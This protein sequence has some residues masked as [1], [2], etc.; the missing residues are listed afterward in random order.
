[1][2]TL[3]RLG[4]LGLLLLCTACAPKTGPQ[5]SAPADPINDI[6]RQYVMLSLEIGMHEE[7]YIDAYYGPAEWKRAAEAAP[8]ALPDLAAAVDALDASL[9]AVDVAGSERLVQ[10]RVTFLRA[11]LNAARTRLR[12]LR[13][14]KLSFRQES[15]GLFGATPD[16]QPLASYDPV[17]AN[18]EALLPGPGTLAE[19]MDAFQERF[20]IPA[21]RLKPVF[22]RAIAE[23]RARTAQHIPLPKGESFR[24]EFVTGKPWSGYNYYQGNLASLIQINTDLPIRISRAVDLGCHEGYPGHHALNYL[25]E[26]RL[27]RARGWM[28]YSVYPLYSPQ[29]LIA[30]GSANYG[31]DLA[32]PGNEKLA[33]EQRE[34]YPLA[35]LATTDA[36]RLETLQKALTG[37]RGAR[38]T[39]AQMYLD[40]QI[41]RAQAIAL[42]QK[43]QLM[44]EAR[45]KQS[46]GFTD[47]YR[48]YVINY[49]LGQDMVREYVE[50]AGPSAKA[51]WA[52]MERV[53]SEPTLP[54]DLAV[55]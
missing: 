49:G 21:D 8:R 41:D 43:Y 4:L 9:A 17:L 39:I 54:V 18:I 22:D 46:I 28:E 3:L 52:A 2:N 42:T 50:A 55:K 7:G 48:S 16:I 12:M 15:L 36:A 37:L 45:A 19:R 29:S 34:L 35:G 40:G 30:E 23:C 1:M 51:R 38:F 10:R 14:E 25:L 27:M 20:V 33:F 24:M 26:Q 5:A 13:G 31:I 47:T 32:F 6:A 53:I 11:Q 44:S